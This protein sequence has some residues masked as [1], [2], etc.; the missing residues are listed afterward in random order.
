ESL[1]PEFDVAGVVRE[2]TGGALPGIVPSNTYT[3]GDGENIVIA[4]NGDAI[5]KRLML[6]MGRIDMAGDP[7]LARNDGRVPRSAEIDEAIGQ[8]CATQTIASALATLQAADVP[9]GK[10]YSVRDMMSDPQYLARG[11]FEQHQF[12][13]GTPVKMPAVSPKLS[14]TPGGTRWLGPALGEHTG[15]VLRALGYCDADIDAM[16]KDGVL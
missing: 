11:M 10:I 2:R 3:T 16:R 6:A 9:A 14:A 13:D 7:Q 15:E 4:G 8:W 1:V 12:A 5:F